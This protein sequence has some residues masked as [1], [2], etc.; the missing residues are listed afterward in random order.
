[1]LNTQELPV[2][3]TLYFQAMKFMSAF[4]L[5]EYQILEARSINDFLKLT[6]SKDDI[7]YLSSH[8]LSIDF[9]AVYFAF[10]KMKN[11]DCVFILWFYHKHINL[12]PMPKRWILTGEHFRKTPTVNE[13]IESWNIQKNLSNYVPM[14]FAS[15]VYPDNIGKHKRNEILKA[16]FVGAP[17]QI[18]WCRALSFPNSGVHIQYTPPFINEETRLSIY[19]SSVVSLGF[20]S[21]NNIKNSVL[22]E[23]V[24]EGLSLGNIVISDNPVCEEATDGNVKYVSSIEDVA[25][26]ID[27][28]WND[29]VARTALQNSGMNWCKNNGTYAHLSQ[30]FI[31]KIKEI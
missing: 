24:F 27:K 10:E 2:I 4:Y 1:M 17:Y 14:T 23:R 13:H 28:Y 3:G 6:P 31:A 18:E 26:Q 16:S 20:H 21:E 12:L 19:L 15:A 22:V 25:S 11:L 30:L 5:S 8:G 7:V 9:N 29:P